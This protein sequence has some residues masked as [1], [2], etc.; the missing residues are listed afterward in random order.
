MKQTLTIL[1]ILAVVVVGYLLISKSNKNNLQG[2]ETG[3]TEDQTDIGGRERFSSPSVNESGTYTLDKKSS[4]VSL[5]TGNGSPSTVTIKSGAL[6]VDKG[7]VSGGDIMLSASDLKDISGLDTK[8]Y[9]EVK[10]AVKALVFDQA[11][12]SIDNLVFRVDT[13]L[14]MNGKTNPMSFPAM[15]D[16]NPG[17]YYISGVA[18]PDWKLW[19]ITLPANESM[20]VNIILNAVK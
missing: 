6:M 7:N 16:Y 2:P 9:P 10:L 4:S 14:T 15:F 17:Q 13:E 19:G 11:K 3:Q 12:S 8:A 20:T 5:N 1:V 18:S